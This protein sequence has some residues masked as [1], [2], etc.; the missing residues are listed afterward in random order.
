MVQCRVDVNGGEGNTYSPCLKDL[1]HEGEHDHK[2]LCNNIGCLCGSLRSRFSEDDRK[3]LLRLVN[4]RIEI[5]ERIHNLHEKYK[6]R[7]A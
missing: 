2:G 1:G 3:E 6:V 4:E 5:E 7:E